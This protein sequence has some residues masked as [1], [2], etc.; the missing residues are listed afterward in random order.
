[1]GK[2]RQALAGEFCGGGH[3]VGWG[4]LDR[5]ARIDRMARPVVATTLWI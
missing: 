3:G 2:K 4:T 5:H 1:M